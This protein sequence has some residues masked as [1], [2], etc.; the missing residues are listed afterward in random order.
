M[1]LFSP[2]HCW[3]RLGIS[4]QVN[5]IIQVIAVIVIHGTCHGSNDCHWSVQMMINGI[6]V[7]VQMVL[8]RAPANSGS[9]WQCTHVL[10]MSGHSEG[11]AVLKECAQKAIGGS[12]S[13]PGCRSHTVQL[14]CVA[15]LQCQRQFRRDCQGSSIL[16]MIAYL[17]CCR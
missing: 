1:P 2:M 10:C 6:M 11:V 4:T 17:S 12:V 7:Q 3:V 9:N 13:L 14:S 5:D 8:V 16:N 15:K